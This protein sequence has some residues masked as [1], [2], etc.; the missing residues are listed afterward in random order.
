MDDPRGK[1]LAA[2]TK[3]ALLTYGQGQDCDV[4]ADS[5]SADKKGL[6]ASL[7]TPEGESEI[8][9]SLI[10]PVNIY[11]ILAA[12][13]AS[14]SIG[15]DLFSIAEGI[16][17]LKSVP[18]R[19]ELVENSGGLT[20]VVDYAHTPDALL[21]AQETLRPM[22][23]GRLITLFGCGG[24][25]DKGKRYE[26]G[27]V[28]GENSDVVF[29]TSD[30][31]RTEEPMSVINQIEEGVRQSGLKKSDWSS[32]S[33]TEASAYFIEVDR[34]KAIEKAVSATNRDDLLLI[35]GKGH[36]DY[37]ILGTE[38]IFFDDR[39]E[40]ARAIGDASISQ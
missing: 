32:D 31:P 35:A 2:V 25:R 5:F 18:G 6:R 14:L 4:R 23:K 34:R 28:A 24:D 22:T 40:V 16:E 38:K 26:M 21:K 39:Y 30:N 3:A 37:Q 12:T 36:E 7:I 20:I 33:G 19:L 9:S 11:N 1:D 8:R 17:R 15:I 13:A 27:L 10:G 29:I